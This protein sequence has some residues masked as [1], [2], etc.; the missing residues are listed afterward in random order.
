M[1]NDWYEQMVEDCKGILVEHEFTS[2]WA[3]VEGY[4]S[5]GK[6][7]LAEHDNFDRS[8]IY[9]G[10]IVARVRESLGKSESTIWRSIQFA[11]KYPD[12]NLLPS[13]K[14]TSWHKVCATFLP[15]PPSQTITEAQD[16]GLASQADFKT[17]E[18]VVAL[19]IDLADAIV[20]LEKMTLHP[21]A[22]DYLC[23]QLRLTSG[24]VGKFLLNNDRKA[25]HNDR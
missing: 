4:H 1:T 3:L 11:K 25:A 15:E 16:E 17:V 13:G 20:E 19:A 24:R 10:E 5:L 18:N 14:D 22:K 7:I 6:R 21:D 2:R 9:G 8:Q 12:L 23:S